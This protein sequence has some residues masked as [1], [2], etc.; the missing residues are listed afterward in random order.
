MS[1][2]ERLRSEVLQPRSYAV[3]RWQEEQDFLYGTD[4][5]DSSEDEGS[6]SSESDTLVQD[7]DDDPSSDD[8]EEEE[9]EADSNVLELD[10]ALQARKEARKEVRKVKRVARKKKRL[11]RRVQTR[12]KKA[13]SKLEKEA[14]KKPECIAEKKR[15]LTLMAN[16]GGFK[17]H[18]ETEALNENFVLDFDLSE[19]PRTKKG[20]VKVKFAVPSSLVG[21]QKRRLVQVCPQKVEQAFQK[22]YSYV[23]R[24]GA[25]PRGEEALKDSRKRFLSCLT[26]IK[27]G[28]PLLIT[29]ANLE[30]DGAVR[31]TDGKHRFCAYRD[32]GLRAIPLLVPAEQAKIFEQRFCGSRRQKRR[33]VQRVGH[34]QACF[35]RQS[36]QVGEGGGGRSEGAVLEP[37]LDVAPGSV[38]SMDS[39]DSMDSL[40]CTVS[41]CADVLA[42]PEHDIPI[43][44]P[45]G[46]REQLQARAAHER[47]QQC[48]NCT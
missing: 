4:E 48:S 28:N 33:H 40:T 34:D 17:H 22:S 23:G 7:R 19:L 35:D 3:R 38:D 32:L 47:V 16:G 14:L 18:A 27:T 6:A 39:I 2:V 30:K 12:F 1:Y 46:R 25:N 45:A 13:M 26:F 36:W 31:F 9:E 37:V 24:Y 5:P 8:E 10:L 44:D 29:C 41:E 21:K 43:D 11:E 15:R 42:C 20:G